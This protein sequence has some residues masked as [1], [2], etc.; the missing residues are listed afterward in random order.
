VVLEGGELVQYHHVV[1]EG[2][3]GV[4][5][6]PS[7]VLPVDDCDI[8]ALHE[9]RFPLTCISDCDGVGEAGQ[10]LPFP[11]LSRPCV[12][13]DSERRDHENPMDLEAVEQEVNGGGQRD[14]RL[15]KA[16]IKEDSGCFVRLNIG[17]TVLLVVMEVTQ[18]RHFLRPPFPLSA[19]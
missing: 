5:D 12:A 13:G 6:Q 15:S 4:V 16:A 3:T 10:V 17:D 1:G 7:K 19:G 2:D 14:D 8:R 11:D 18:F 9:S